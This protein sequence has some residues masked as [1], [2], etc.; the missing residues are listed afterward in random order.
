MNQKKLI[1]SVLAISLFVSPL[2]ASRIEEIKTKFTNKVYTPSTTWLGKEATMYHPTGTFSSRG[3]FAKHAI[4]SAVA[5]KVIQDNTSINDLLKTAFSSAT[6]TLLVPA[7]VDLAD[8]VYNTAKKDDSSA[9]VAKPTTP[10]ARKQNII[11]TLTAITY[12]IGQNPEFFGSFFSN[13]Q[14][15]GLKLAL[16][17]MVERLLAKDLSRRDRLAFLVGT[18]AP[19]FTTQINDHL[20]TLKPL[21]SLDKDKLGKVLKLVVNKNF[22]GLLED[23]A[24]VYWMSHTDEQFQAKRDAR[25]ADRW[26]RAAHDDL[27]SDMSPE[28]FATKHPNPKVA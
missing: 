17:E 14:E 18:L 27:W 23:P 5:A 13:V 10:S 1:A 26:A 8:Y 9:S 3:S 22:I 6:G 4:L 25:G 11:L 12:V 16:E 7:I 15:N 21:K 2:S 28:D 24:E 20:S 19:F